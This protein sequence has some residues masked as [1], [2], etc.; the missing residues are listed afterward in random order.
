[1]TAAPAPAED[2]YLSPTSLR[3]IREAHRAGDLAPLP[4]A[5]QARIGA[6][7]PRPGSLLCI[8]QNYAAHAAESVAEPPEQPILYFTPANTVTGLNDDVAIPSN[9]L[10]TD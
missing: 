2:H 6:P 9:S 8:G 5:G 3:T 4:N 10:K 7:I 1:S